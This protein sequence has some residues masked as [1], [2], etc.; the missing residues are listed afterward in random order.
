LQEIGDDFTT[1]R[2]INYSDYEE[3]EFEQAYR[4][5]IYDYEHPECPTC[6]RRMSRVIKHDEY[7]GHWLPRE[8]YECD[9][10]D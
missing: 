1:I 10:C 2:R 9:I 6:G 7:C 4:R 5:E 3:D 8:V